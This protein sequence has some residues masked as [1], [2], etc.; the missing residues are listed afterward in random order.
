MTKKNFDEKNRNFVIIYNFKASP[1]VVFDINIHVKL[2]KFKRGRSPSSHLAK[3][4]DF[5]QNHS[6]TFTVNIVTL[7][8]II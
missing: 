3:E 7:L 2:E 5:A 8:S 4:G 1:V 6:A